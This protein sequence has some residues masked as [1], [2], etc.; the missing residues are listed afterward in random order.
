MLRFKLVIFDFDGT[1][2]DTFEWFQGALNEAAAKFHFRT[3]KDHELEQM[4]H[5]DIHQIIRHLKI[6]WWKRPFIAH[7]M[8]KKMRQDIQKLKLFPDVIEMLNE[9]HQQ[10]FKLAIVS[11]NAYENITYL[12]GPETSKLINFYECGVSLFGK[13]KRFQKL[14]RSLNLDPAEAIYIGDETRDIDAARSVGMNF[15]AVSWGYATLAILQSKSPEMSFK[16]VTE[17]SQALKN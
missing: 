13:K 10:G 5:F 14:L 7:F 8:R 9:L 15:G 1:L 11:S 6:S 16:S 12:L 17:I 3:I 4:R 2:G